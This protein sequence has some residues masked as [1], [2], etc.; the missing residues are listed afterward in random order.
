MKKS[1]HE[2]LKTQWQ[3]IVNDQIESGQ[4]IREWCDYNRISRN[5]FYYWQRVIREEALV[6]AGTLALTGQAQFVEVKS[7]N[8]DSILSNNDVCAIIRS[9][10][11]EIEI[12]NGSDPTTLSLLL[13][14]M[15][16]RYEG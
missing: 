13:S 7:S 4:S 1:K 14:F 6:K 9:G 2:I 16:G 11:H 3:Q 8:K 15:V 5:K 12:V 10:G